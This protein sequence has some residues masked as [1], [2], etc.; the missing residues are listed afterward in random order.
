[1]SGRSRSAPPPASGRITIERLRTLLTSPK[2]LASDPEW[3]TEGDKAKLTIPIEIEGLTV[4]GR[5][6]RSTAL[7]RY[8]MRE[9][10][11]G[12]VYLPG[13]D[14]GGMF[15]RIDAWPFRR[16]VNKGHGPKALR[17]RVFAEGE[18]QHQGLEIN[19]H[20]PVDQLL[21]NLPIAQPIE[22]PLGSWRDLMR[23]ASKAWR[24]EPELMLPSPP[25]QPDLLSAQG[26]TG[27]AGGRRR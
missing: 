17:F 18:S 16:H 21:D 14:E 8:P 24:F 5:Q 1:M 4:E 12:L 20:L 22:P 2:S 3:R 6:L 25:W 19:A 10:T 13:G 26:T 27:R 7:V 9:V 15:E 23:H 11:L